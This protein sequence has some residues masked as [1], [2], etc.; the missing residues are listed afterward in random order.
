MAKDPS[1]AV[2]DCLAK[3]AVLHEI[4]AHLTLE[5]FR[6]DPIAR[7]AAAYAIQTVLEAVRH[8]PAEWLAEYPS[9]PGSDQGCRQSD[10]P[11][12]FSSR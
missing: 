1:I 6:G 3:I 10:S 11:R 5:E 12:V 2:R 9:Q 4:A 7:R 8:I